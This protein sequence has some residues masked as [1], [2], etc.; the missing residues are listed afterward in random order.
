M[1]E[2]KKLNEVLNEMY[3]SVVPP[4]H[5]AE[6]EPDEPLSIELMAKWLHAS[7]QQTKE[8]AESVD[9]FLKEGGPHKAMN[10]IGKYFNALLASIY[11]NQ[12]ALVWLHNEWHK[13]ASDS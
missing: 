10:H 9:A 2:P 4:E 13:K 12:D 1:A 3:G 5:V 6:F 7:A 11:N 8:T